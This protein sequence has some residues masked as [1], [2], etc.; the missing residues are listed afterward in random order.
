MT[1][2]RSR[3]LR[4]TLPLAAAAWSA[5]LLLEP[6]I[7]GAAGDD[8]GT[9]AVPV[10]PIALRLIEE[11]RRLP[12]DLPAVVRFATAKN[13]DILEARARYAEA[14]GR[15]NEV[16]GQLLP[17]VRTSFAARKIDGQIQASFGELDSRSFSTILPA[18]KVEMGFNV[19]QAIFDALAANRVLGASDVDIDEVTQDVLARATQQ[20]FNLLDAQARV[21]IG[22]EAVAASQ[23][24]S[25]LANHR[26]V[27]GVGLKVDVLRGEARLAA[28]EILLAQTGKDFRTESLR[29]AQTLRLDPTVTLFPMD[30]EVRQLTLIGDSRSV[31]SLVEQALAHRPD[32]NAQALRVSAAENKHDSSW[33]DAVG[34]TVYGSFEESGI[35]RST[36]NIKDRQI[37]GGFVGFRFSPA[38]VGSVRA[39]GAQV[40]I[41]RLRAERIRQRVEIEVIGA[42]EEVLTAAEQVGAALRGVRAAEASLELSQVR[43]EGGAGIALE[44]L[45]AQA[46][47]SA[48]RTS[49]VT[50]IVSYN[51]AQV[52]L[53]RAVGG[54]SAETLLEGAD[55][56][57]LRP[58]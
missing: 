18:A 10:A 7:A 48:N 8:P 14:E 47:V 40:D 23:E 57:P 1:V 33:A 19:G 31:D 55:G 2:M 38:S 15:R 51:A 37:Y 39:A 29:L 45:E 24:F 42:R 13:L 30:T 46:A 17:A 35:G 22:Q 54:V 6:S 3:R 21:A 11:G 9:A 50:S 53:L 27:Q 28:E 49:L 58:Q 25:R 12:I 41:E 52:E 16:L 4:W 32:I 43:Y 36:G 5:G 56:A 26:E 44:V 34:P 20:Y